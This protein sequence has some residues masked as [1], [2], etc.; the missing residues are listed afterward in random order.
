MLLIDIGELIF[1]LEKYEFHSSHI[2]NIEFIK[3]LSLINAKPVKYGHWEWFE[4]WLPSNSEHPAECEETGW[5]CSECKA[6]LEETVGGYW[7]CI[8]ER[9]KIK[10]CPAC[11]AKMSGSK[12]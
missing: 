12:E 4:D 3:E 1:R 11:G 9:P 8:E 7:D 10:Y 2:T 5:R 6:S